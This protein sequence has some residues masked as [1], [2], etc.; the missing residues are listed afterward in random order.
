[1]ASRSMTVEI[2]FLPGIF[3]SVFFLSFKVV[4]FGVDPA[5]RINVFNELKLGES[6]A[7]VSQ[8]HGFH[9]KSRAFQ[10]QGKIVS[11]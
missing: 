1:M 8:V 5:L 10:F 7:G 2:T 3:V 11:V 4:G 6:F 9:N